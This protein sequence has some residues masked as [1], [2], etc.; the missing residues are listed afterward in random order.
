MQVIDAKYERT[1]IDSQQH[2]VGT[3]TVMFRNHRQSKFYDVDARDFQRWAVSGYG[4]TEVPYDMQVAF[5]V[6][7]YR[8]DRL[9]E[10]DES[11]D[12]GDEMD[13]EGSEH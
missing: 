3:V 9:A 7:N 11:D 2:E 13:S 6:E 5:N 8:L 4:P 12:A 10:T 1:G